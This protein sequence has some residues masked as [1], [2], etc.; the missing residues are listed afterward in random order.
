MFTDPTLLTSEHSKPVA[1]R[2]SAVAP[3]AQ[4]CQPTVQQGRSAAGFVALPNAILLDTYLSC[5]ARV[6]Y[7]ILLFHA[8]QNGQCFPALATLCQEVGMGET[9]VRQYLHELSAA[10][11]ISQRRRGQG[12]TNLYILHGPAANERTTPTT[13]AEPEPPEAAPC[14]SSV[15]ADLADVAGQEA[16]TGAADE[17]R[18]DSD[19]RFVAS[20]FR[21]V[22]SEPATTTDRSVSTS[23]PL[24][25][26]TAHADTASHRTETRERA[27]AAQ[28]EPDRRADDLRYQALVRPLTALTAEFGDVA[29]VRSNVT[30][31]YHLLVRSCLSCDEFLQLV[32]EA[33]SIT[34]ARR[35]RITKRCVGADNMICSNMMPYWFSVL[36]S[37]L[38][39]RQARQQPH[40]STITC[41]QELR[42]RQ[43]PSCTLVPSRANTNSKDDDTIMERQNAAVQT[44]PV[45]RCGVQ[46]NPTHEALWQCV[47]A[48]LRRMLAPAAYARCLAGIVRSERGAVLQIEAHD[49]AL[50]WWFETRLR[51]AI[52]AA[53]ADLGQARLRVVFSS[54]HS[55]VD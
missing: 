52:E 6:L 11:L 18:D 51:R 4:A 34:L 42:E 16:R 45:Q 44:H 2:Q 8:R 39:Q 14:T 10:G 19:D 46:D 17:E 40:V 12:R 30:R 29:P 37:L 15:P 50:L 23:G 13:T 55:D 32:A 31:A 3:S 28:P 35:G 22:P 1:P 48:E 26:G 5:A 21:M 41:T 27:A 24:V 53:L 36:T 33:R 20:N 38:Q 49:P 54:P 7:G 9:S 43:L 47:L 25:L